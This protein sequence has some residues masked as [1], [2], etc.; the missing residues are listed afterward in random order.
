[1]NWFIVQYK[2]SVCVYVYECVSIFMSAHCKSFC[3]L[4]FVVDMHQRNGN[5]FRT[6]Y[7]LPLPISVIFLSRNI[8]FNLQKR[9]SHP[10]KLRKMRFLNYEA[11]LWWESREKI[12][13]ITR[14]NFW[15]TSEK[16]KTK[17]RTLVWSKLF[18]FESQ[19]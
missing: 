17:I 11:A 10:V 3:C 6:L 16:K 5:V 13:D 12:K 8:I 15:L 14:S 18:H 7:I 1:M 2:G 4:K 9:H 19:A